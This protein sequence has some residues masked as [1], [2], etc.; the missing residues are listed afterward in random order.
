M[1]NSLDTIW[2]L[3]RQ[4]LFASVTSGL[5]KRQGARQ[6]QFLR[7]PLGRNGLAQWAAS[8]YRLD[9]LR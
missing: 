1:F 4:R 7:L 2:D 6:G 5:V 9:A 3:L 8:L